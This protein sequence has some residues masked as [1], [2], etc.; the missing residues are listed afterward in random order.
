MPRGGSFRRPEHRITLVW[1]DEEVEVVA[2][3]L[4]NVD[5]SQADAAG[6]RFLE[7]RDGSHE[8]AFPRAVRTQQ[9]V[10]SMRYGERNIV[11][12]FNAIGVCLGERFDFQ[13]HAVLVA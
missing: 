13:F 7:R 1:T 6:I 2:R 4:E 10:H 8:S 12:S 9:T 11:K 3:L 5:V